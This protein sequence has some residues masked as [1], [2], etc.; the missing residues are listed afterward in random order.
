[1]TPKKKNMEPIFKSCD[2]WQ[3]NACLNWSFDPLDL[4][5]MGYKDAAEILVKKATEKNSI[6]DFLIYPICFLYRQYI[7]LCLKEIIQ[8]GRILLDKGFDFPQHHKLIKLW[9]IA[10]AII[11]EVFSNNNEQIN[12]S[13][14]EHIISEFSRIDPDSFSFRYPCDKKGNN[15]LSGIKYVNLRHLSDNMSKFGK[16]I[17]GISNVI[18][19]YLEQKRD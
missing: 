2:D 16:E 1:M 9:E 13:F 12:L 14:I 19:V 3:F 7:E 6:V 8:S 11:F 10:K 17:D 4:Y 18:S 5:V 15:L